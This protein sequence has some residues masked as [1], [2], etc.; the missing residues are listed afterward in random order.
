VKGCGNNSE[1]ITLE[2]GR[3]YLTQRNHGFMANDGRWLIE[4]LPRLYWSP[5]GV[6]HQASAYELIGV[7]DTREAALA[8]AA[9][10]GDAP[11]HDRPVDYREP[12]SVRVGTSLNQ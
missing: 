10:A 8:A 12:Y 11:E 5:I 2:N 3:F 4:R 7:F 9:A 1:T 6:L